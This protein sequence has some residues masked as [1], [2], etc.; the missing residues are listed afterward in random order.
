MKTWEQFKELLRES[1]LTQAELARRLGEDY[2]WVNNRLRGYSALK[3]DDILPIAQ[4]LGVSPCAFFERP[5]AGLGR[6][7]VNYYN[8]TVQ[9]TNRTR[10]MADDLSS[11]TGEPAER[12]IERAVGKLWGDQL[13]R[14]NSAAYEALR[15]NP[16]D[17]QAELRERAEWDATL[18]DGLDKE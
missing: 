9:I 11:T 2:A 3:A 17:W 6:R 13:L 4:A 7:A 15:A 16:K 14:E 8:R 5:A 18:T 10:D 12:V 1:G